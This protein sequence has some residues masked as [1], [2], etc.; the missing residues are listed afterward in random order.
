MFKPLHYSIWCLI[1]T[2]PETDFCSDPLFLLNSLARLSRVLDLTFLCFL[3]IQAFF[4]PSAGTAL[5]AFPSSV[6]SPCRP[7]DSRSW[8]APKPSV[9]A[10]AFVR[11]RASTKTTDEKTEKRLQGSEG[12]LGMRRR[13]YDLQCKAR[14]IKE[15]TETENQLEW[16]NS[17]HRYYT[18]GVVVEKLF[19]PVFERLWCTECRN[20]ER[21][22][23]YD[24]NKY[25]IIA[26]C[27]AVRQL[28]DRGELRAILPF[29]SIIRDFGNIF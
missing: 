12:H 17:A 3:P 19:S 29:S 26:T 10:R 2:A 7:R 6:P 28:L 20:Q 5:S 23:T 16:N 18:I 13:L 21:V 27:Y 25:L 4:L 22:S 15:R 8:S 1:S 14:R 9:L 24:N 11:M